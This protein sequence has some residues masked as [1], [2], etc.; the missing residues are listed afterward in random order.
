MKIAIINPNSTR[1]MTEK[2]HRVAAQFVSAGTEIISSNPTDTP[3]SIEGH[4]DEAMS[5]PSLLREMK[6]AEAAGAD[7]FVLAC[8]D[9]PGLHACREIV[10]GP[11]VGI[12]EAAMHAASMLATS[13]SVVTTLQRSVPIIEEL[14]HKYGMA[15]FCR[16]VRAADIPVLQLEEPGKKGDEARQKIKDEIMRAAA[17]DNCEAVILGCAGM[18]DL[19]QQLTKDC[20]LPVIDGVV[21]AVKLCEALIGAGLK[22]SKINAYASPRAK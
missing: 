16:K 22:T 1:G 13:F 8:F 15:H 14:A 5:L 12:C 20:G 17:E 19:T 10:A 21:T 7:G 18:A 9:D 6:K 2:C 4:Y 11:V 3:A